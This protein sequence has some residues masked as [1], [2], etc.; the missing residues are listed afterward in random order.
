MVSHLGGIRHYNKDYL[1]NSSKDN[2]KDDT[3]DN[4]KDNTKDN[5]KDSSRDKLKDSF[6]DNSPSSP[7]ATKTLGKKNPAQSLKVS[8]EFLYE[9]YYIKDNFDSTEAAL[10]LFKDDPLVHKPGELSLFEV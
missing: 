2:L 1:Q 7:P 4:L 8:G 10:A 5:L 6:K 3:K 9:E